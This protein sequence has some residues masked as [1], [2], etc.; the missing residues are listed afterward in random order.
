MAALSPT[1]VRADPLQGFNFLISLVDV[2]SSADLLKSAAL[3]AVADVVLGGFSECSGLEMT[4][5]VHDYAEG[6][7]N[8]CTLH[9]P[10]PVKWG[11][12]TLKKGLGASTALWD[13]HYG[14]V[15]GT[16]TR[17]DGVIS[18]MDGEHVPNTIWYFKKGLPV[19]Y[20]G[21]AMNASTSAVAV[22]SIEIAHEGIY[23][24]PGVAAGA[25]GVL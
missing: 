5:A 18:L 24:L 8:G 16:G 12:I 9:F 21:P 2:T 7:N 10:A 1:G 13:W 4:M 22:E 25:G 6:G 20:S 3:S 15:V 11:N 19:K 17:R 14:F 23:Q